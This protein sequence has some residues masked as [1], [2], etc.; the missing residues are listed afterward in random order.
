METVQDWIT[1][2]H[3]FALFQYRNENYRT[4]IS[5]CYMN[6]VDLILIQAKHIVK[7]CHDNDVQILHQN[8]ILKK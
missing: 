7:E 1:L 2:Y 5:H 3:H 4:N 6:I 8:T